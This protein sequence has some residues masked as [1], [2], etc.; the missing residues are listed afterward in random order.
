MPALV[1]N[2]LFGITLTLFVYWL[3]VLIYRKTNELFLFQ[4]LFFGMVLGILALFGLSR[5][6]GQSI[7]AVHQ[8][9]A[10]GGDILFWLTAPA[11][12]SF[13]IPLYQRRDILKK[14]WP[15]ILIALNISLCISLFLIYWLCEALGMSTRLT[16]AL[17]V[18]AATT[19]I[20]QP[21][22]S[23]IGGEPTIAALAAILNSVI[24][25]ALGDHFIRWFRLKNQPL[26]SGLGFGMAGNAVGAT[27]AI[28]ISEVSGA[29]AVVAFVFSG[30]LVNLMVPV[31]ARL[32]GL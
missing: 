21:V 5:I 28:T 13:A 16:G 2:P 4:P 19:A 8:A 15:L 7:E 6:L 26:G 18:Q 30:L 27:K 22:A 10:K 29:A 17:L 14:Y 9:Y 11:T 31:F 12:M 32:I 3:S 20:A 24:V 25:Y 23:A 1:Q